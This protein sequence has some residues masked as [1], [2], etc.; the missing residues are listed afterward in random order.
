M[1]LPLVKVG[2]V[3]NWDPR[4]S[5]RD[6][7]ATINDDEH[8]GRVPVYAIGTVAPGEDGRFVEGRL[9]D[10]DEARLMLIVFDNLNDREGVRRLAEHLADEIKMPV[11]VQQASAGVS[12]ESLS[13]DDLRKVGLQRIPTEDN[14]LR[15]PDG[16][17]D[18]EPRYWGEG[19]WSDGR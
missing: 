9:V 3:K 6:N 1:S 15:G 12:I 19:E 5:L 18:V 10:L 16:A 11:V 17:L 4:F 2:Y 8:P 7:D 13:D 14:D